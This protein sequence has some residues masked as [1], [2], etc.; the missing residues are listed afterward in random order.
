MSATN[1]HTHYCA[2]CGNV[3]QCWC[4]NEYEMSEER[5]CHTCSNQYRRIKD[6]HN[7]KNFKTLQRPNSWRR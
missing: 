3:F 5:M 4:T 2:R 1:E 7:F 6:A